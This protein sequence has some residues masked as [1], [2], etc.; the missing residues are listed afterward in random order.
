[1]K[2]KNAECLND[3]SSL[4]DKYTRI[5]RIFCKYD[6]VYKQEFEQEEVK[7]LKNELFSNQVL[8]P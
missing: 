2:E 1:M 6:S 8:M 3:I 7:V 5:V 4:V